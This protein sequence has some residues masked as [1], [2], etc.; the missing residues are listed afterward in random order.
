[1]RMRMCMC[2]YVCVCVCVILK[3]AH[4]ISNCHSGLLGTGNKISHEYAVI[5][6]KLPPFSPVQC[7]CVSVC[8]CVC[9]CVCVSVCP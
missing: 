7:V 6:C 9:V 5:T 4:D 2:V 1:M 8:V 3:Q